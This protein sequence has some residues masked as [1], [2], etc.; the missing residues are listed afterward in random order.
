MPRTGRLKGG[1][2]QDCLPHIPS[3][4]SHVAVSD[5]KE[6]TEFNRPLAL[7]FNHVEWFER[8]ARLETGAQG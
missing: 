1:C 8:L 6:L 5:G 2:R 3:E 4:A 7:R